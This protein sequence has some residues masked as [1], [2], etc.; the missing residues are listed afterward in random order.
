M[1]NFLLQSGRQRV[2]ALALIPALVGALAFG[3]GSAL[4]AFGDNPVTFYGCVESRTHLLYN[5]LT[6]PASPRACLKDDAAVSWSQVGPAGPAGATGPQG[7]R[8]IQGPAGPKGDA[9]AAGATG[10]Q[11]SKGDTGP[12][13]PV[14][15][16]GAMG[17]AGP[18]GPKGDTGDTG[19]S[20]PQGPKGDTGPAGPVGTTGATG[21]QGAQGLQ[22]PQ[23][24]KGD[25]G[26]TGATGGA[27]P[28]GPQGPAG[29]DA[30][31]HIAGYVAG[32][33]TLQSLPTFTSKRRSTGWYQIDFP[34]GTWSAA[35]QAVAVVTAYE[36]EFATCQV[37]NTFSPGDGSDGS[38]QVLVRC[39][40]GEVDKDSSFGFIVMQG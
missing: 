29:A 6:S 37:V 13:G 33:G 23:G 40:V 25:T 22:G 32:T 17:A 36:F 7:P 28:Q 18:Q 39:G 3:A 20:G 12:A 8:G 24:P 9:G 4:T 34:T 5:V 11:G 2:L 26:A 38:L 16:T 1:S 10:P 31:K 30:P 19:A 35:R 15:P 27:G 21:P 14:G